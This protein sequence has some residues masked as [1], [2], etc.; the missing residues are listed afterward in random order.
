VAYETV[1]VGS[2]DRKLYALDARTGAVRWERRTFGRVS[3]GP[4]IIGDV[5][6][7]SSLEKATDAFGV[8]TGRKVWS[9][10][11]GK[12]NPGISD[13]K[14]FYFVGATSLFAFE[15][16]S[17]GKRARD[18]R[19]DRAEKRAAARR[20]AQRKRYLRFRFGLHGHRHVRGKDGEIPSCHL[21]RHVYRVEGERRVLK[22]DHCHKHVPDRRGQR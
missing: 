22:H 3:G 13:G 12:F 1:F 19:R 5:V 10:R 15:P 6:Y 21:H 8:R 20:R 17:L 18:R 16:K 11:R 7:A 14:R 4:S 9:I 2:Y